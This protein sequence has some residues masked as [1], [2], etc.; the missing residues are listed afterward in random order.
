M[1]I[2]TSR[3]R[4]N[5]ILTRQHADAHD[6]IAHDRAGFVRDDEKADG[7]KDG[8]D[9]LICCAVYESCFSR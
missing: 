9:I 5:H 1:V 2:L 4:I 3:K 7:D 8:I 6:V